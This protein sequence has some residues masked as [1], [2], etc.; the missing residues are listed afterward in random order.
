VFGGCRLAAAFFDK[1]S[2]CSSQI[3]ELVAQLQAHN[4][5]LMVD[6][7]HLLR[8][9]EAANT[10]P[11]VRERIIAGD[12]SKFRLVKFTLKF[13]CFTVW[14]TI[15]AMAEREAFRIPLKSSLFDLQGC[16]FSVKPK[17]HCCPLDLCEIVLRNRVFVLQTDAAYLDQMKDVLAKEETVLFEFKDRR[18]GYEHAIKMFQDEIIRCACIMDAIIL[19][20]C[21]FAVLWVID[22]LLPSYGCVDCNGR[23]RFS[24][25]WM[26]AWTA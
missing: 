12:M 24:W 23:R 20:A 10:Q 2:V 17:T 13:Y 14:C 11:A 3:H 8:Y 25:S 4:E 19:F 22:L 7:Q 1:E 5:K 16:L 18:P 21:M 26:N 15:A 9:C 6:T